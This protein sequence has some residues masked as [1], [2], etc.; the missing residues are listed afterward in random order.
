MIIERGGVKLAVIGVCTPDI[1]IWDDGQEGISDTVFEAG[2]T[3]VKNALEE[4]GDKADIIMVSAH[5]GEY[6]EFDEE[7]GSDSAIK[8]AE[9]NPDIDLL[10]VAHMHITVDDGGGEARLGILR[11]CPRHDC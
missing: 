5:M 11:I 2:D 8:I 9:E 3:A 1:P 6:A 7:G 10:Q 4:I